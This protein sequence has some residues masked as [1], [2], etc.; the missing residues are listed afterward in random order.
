MD[1]LKGIGKNFSPLNLGLFFLAQLWPSEGATEESGYTERQSIRDLYLL[2]QGEVR[3]SELSL[4]WHTYW[5][6]L[7]YLQIK[8]N[9]PPLPTI[10]P[11]EYSK[12]INQ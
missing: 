3:R 4:K 7:C 5:E 10:L 6:E 1:W 9:P 11:M 2:F 12:L 8:F